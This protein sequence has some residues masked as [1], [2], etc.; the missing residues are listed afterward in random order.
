L[1]VTVNTSIQTRSVSRL[2]ERSIHPIVWT[3]NLEYM[4]AGVKFSTKYVYTMAAVHYG[5]REGD[6]DTVGTTAALGGHIPL[7]AGFDVEVQGSVTHLVPRPSQKQINGNLWIAPQ[8][9]G[10]YSFASHLRVFAGGGVR[11]PGFVDLG[12]DVIRPEVLAGV[13]F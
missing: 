6:L 11:L 5:P 9:I 10:G 12:R 13:Q 7:P 4:N 2:W 8:V 3:S 1:D